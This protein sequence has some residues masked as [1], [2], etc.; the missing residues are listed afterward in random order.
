MAK[1]VVYTKSYCPFCDR[2]KDLLKRKG[3]NFEEVFLDDK[4]EEYAA[5]KAKTG[6]M[7]VPQIFI[8]DQLIGGYTDMAAL[9]KENKLDDLLSQ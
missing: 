7:T 5:L 1:V 3:V 6:L 2:A 8:N 9:D 4:P